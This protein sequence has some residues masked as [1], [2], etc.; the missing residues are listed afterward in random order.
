MNKI[1]DTQL[2]ALQD[3]AINGPATRWSAEKTGWYGKTV[4]D[5]SRDWVWGWEAGGVLNTSTVRAL[6]KRRLVVRQLPDGSHQYDHEFEG[7]ID[8]TAGGADALLS[9]I[10]S[11]TLPILKALCDR[12][13]LVKREA[14][15]S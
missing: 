15:P 7:D 9:A 1:S 6:L 5:H 12:I 11:K 3:I 8:L 4:P 2:S 10:E 13:A 14:G